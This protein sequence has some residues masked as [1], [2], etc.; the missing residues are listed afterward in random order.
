MLFRVNGLALFRAQ[1]TSLPD[2]NLIFRKAVQLG[3]FVEHI[4]L[5]NCRVRA[6]FYLLRLMATY[7]HL[8]NSLR[9]AGHLARQELMKLY[10]YCLM[11]L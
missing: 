1:T 7:L 2:S 4:L 10:G 5:H 9:Q 6:T 11:G 8:L 3:V